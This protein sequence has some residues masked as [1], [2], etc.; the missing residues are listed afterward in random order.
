MCLLMTEPGEPEGSSGL[1]T[2]CIMYDRQNLNECG[3]IHIHKNVSDGVMIFQR[4]MRHCVKMLALAL[5]QSTAIQ[6]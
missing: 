2:S 5:A 6:R 3:D 1:I 4:V